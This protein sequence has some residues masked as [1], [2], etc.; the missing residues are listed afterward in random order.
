MSQE[1]MSAG[2]IAGARSWWG[3]LSPRAR[4]NVLLFAVLAPVALAV[5][6]PYLWMLTTSLKA[7]GTTGLPPYLFPTHFEF[8][9]YL[10]A[11]KAAPFLRY[12]L[13]TTVVAAVVIAA[14]VVLAGMA[15]YA[16]AFL[17]FVFKA[18]VVGGYR[19]DRL[20]R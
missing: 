20:L 10:I 9:N 13:N 18:A 4:T 1:G 17:K 19:L 8:Q 16:F 11:W 5:L 2:G 7:R 6:V 15:A 14:R 12:Y 3:R